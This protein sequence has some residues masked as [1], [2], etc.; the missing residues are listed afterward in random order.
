MVEKAAWPSQTDIETA[1][2]SACK[3]ATNDNKS[4][5]RGRVIKH[6]HHSKINGD[7][8]EMY[9]NIIFGVNDL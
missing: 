1:T 3:S 5:R 6:Q 2:A 8:T 7:D 9:K 4:A